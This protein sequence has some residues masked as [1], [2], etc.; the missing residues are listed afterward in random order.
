MSIHKNAEHMF[1]DDEEISICYGG[2]DNGNLYVDVKIEDIARLLAD[3]SKIL[4]LKKIIKK[5]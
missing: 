5:K 4:E 3:K 1:A 2:D